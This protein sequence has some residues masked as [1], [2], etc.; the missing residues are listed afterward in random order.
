MKDS[1]IKVGELTVRIEYD[2]SLLI[3][4]TCLFL[5]VV[6]YALTIRNARKA[7]KTIRN[8]T[9]NVNKEDYLR[10]P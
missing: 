6:L 7:K 3:S 4:L 2:V 5:I 9:I 1:I 10:N 8:E